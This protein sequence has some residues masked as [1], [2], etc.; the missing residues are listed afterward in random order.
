MPRGDGEFQPCTQRQ[1]DVLADFGYNP[2]DVSFDEASDIL[3]ELK[4]NGWKRPEPQR[5]RAAPPTHRQRSAPTVNTRGTQ[6]R[7]RSTHRPATHGSNTR[8]GGVIRCTNKQAATLEKFGY[9]PNVSFDEARVIL[10]ELA[11]NDWTRPD[12]DIPFQR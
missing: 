8:P 5:E 2:D 11:A 10:D 3:D 12:N 7:Q 1:A 6:S 4:K 9:D